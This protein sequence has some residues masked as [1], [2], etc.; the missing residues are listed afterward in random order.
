MKENMGK[1]LLDIGKLIVGGLIIGGILRSAISQ[2]I[3]ITSGSVAAIILFIL[4][5]FWTMKEKKEDK[6]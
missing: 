4:G 1:L 3:L 5:I 6:G 2:V